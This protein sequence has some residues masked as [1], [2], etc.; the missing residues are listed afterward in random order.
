VAKHQY[1]AH[2]IN[3]PKQKTY[4]SINYSSAPDDVPKHVERTIKNFPRTLESVHSVG[5]NNYLCLYVLKIFQRETG[6][7]KITIRMK[8]RLEKTRSEHKIICKSVLVFT[9]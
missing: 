1:K 6:K 3:T 4:G 8:E 5:I 9:Y 7:R 2:G